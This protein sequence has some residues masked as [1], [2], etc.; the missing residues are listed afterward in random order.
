MEREGN[1]WTDGWMDGG[2]RKREREATAI[3]SLFPPSS[4][5]SLILSL[6]L[7]SPSTWG[8]ISASSRMRMV[9]VMKPT[10]PPANE[11]TRMGKNTLATV[12]AIKRVHISQLP[13]SRIGRRDPERWERGGACGVRA[14][15]GRL[16]E[17]RRAHPSLRRGPFNVPGRPT[18]ALGRPRH[19]PRWLRQD[20]APAQGG[21]AVQRAPRRRQG[22][23]LFLA[24][25]KPTRGTP[26][27]LRP[28]QLTCVP[29]LLLRVAGRG[30]NL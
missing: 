12:L 29:P 23:A 28:L 6:S 26:L 9:E 3:S 1:G 7:S 11:A 10:K 17:G 4:R 5:T 2:R 8:T 15:R 18:R 30:D 24:P 21:K 16:K 13:F 19:H 22:A 27:A 20:K 25:S 14:R